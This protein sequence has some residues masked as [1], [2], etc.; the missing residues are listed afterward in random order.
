MIDRRIKGQS[1][2][3]YLWVTY[4][5][6]TATNTETDKDL[7]T[8]IPT[9]NLVKQLINRVCGGSNISGIILDSSNKLHITDTEGNDI[10]EPVDMS[11]FTSEGKTISKFGTIAIT[12]EDINNG[13]QF[14]L[15]TICN[16]IQVGN[17][18]YYASATNSSN[19]IESY[20]ENGI[21]KSKVKIDNS[22]NINL[23]IT[24][25]GLKATFPIK[26]TGNPIEIEYL[27]SDPT[28]FKDNTIYYIKNKPYFYFGNNKIS[29]GE[30]T[31]IEN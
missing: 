3:D 13:C 30:S 21:V 10:G 5:G 16:F 15:G 12:Q 1:Q 6:L 17:T 4:G 20:L 18:K 26:N 7:D 2:L 14:P 11:I 23:N 28:E 22:S 24:D 25:K 8:T 29:G 19:S 31:W 9:Y 27:D